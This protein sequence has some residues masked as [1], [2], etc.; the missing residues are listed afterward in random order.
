MQQFLPM[1]SWLQ[2]KF[3]NSHQNCSLKYQALLNLQG[4]EWCSVWAIM[5]DFD[6]WRVFEIRLRATHWVFPPAFI[7]GKLKKKP[8]NT[9]F[10]SQN[11]EVVGEIEPKL[12][13]WHNLTRKGRSSHGNDHIYGV[14]TV[15]LAET[16]PNIR[17]YTVHMQW[18][19]Q[20][21]YWIVH[22]HYMGVPG[23]IGFTECW[24]FTHHVWGVSTVCVCSYLCNSLLIQ[25]TSLRSS[26]YLMGL[27]RRLFIWSCCCLL[28]CV[29]AMTK[30]REI[31]CNVCTMACIAL[32]ALHSV[33]LIPVTA[34]AR[35]GCASEQITNTH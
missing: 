4:T 2:Y 21:Y 35:I 27:S 13:N 11:G 10:S 33:L 29:R 22:T 14:Y 12:A 20:P 25:P 23:W 8:S 16:L 17:P 9:T 3:P 31:D 1:L 34:W 26:W 30:Y 19:G 18:V 7:S 28:I 32:E 5:A 24:S 6:P 15:F